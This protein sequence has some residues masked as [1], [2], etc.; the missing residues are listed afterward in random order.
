MKMDAIGE[1]QFANSKGKI[2][3]AQSLSLIY[4]YNIL[5]KIYFKNILSFNPKI[6]T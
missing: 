3:I 1:R 5:G 2:K 6:I 4:P